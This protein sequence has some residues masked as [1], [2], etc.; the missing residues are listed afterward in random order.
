MGQSAEHR[1]V[2]S[3]FSELLVM[4]H[5][6]VAIPLAHSP[7]HLGTHPES[8]MSAPWNC[9][10]VTNDKWP[11]SDG[12]LPSRLLSNNCNFVML[13]SLPSS[14]GIVPVSAFPFRCKWVSKM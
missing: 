6:V 13:A 9:T 10:D 3:G 8:F 7:R 4:S 5:E 14:G 2:T 11:S 1:P 12:M